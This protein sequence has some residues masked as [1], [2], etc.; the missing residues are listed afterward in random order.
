MGWSVR[1]WISRPGTGPPMGARAARWAAMPAQV[2]AWGTSAE[3]SAVPAHSRTGVRFPRSP[4]G[5]ARTR[6]PPR[7]YR[8][9]LRRAESNQAQPPV[10]RRPLQRASTIRSRQ[11]HWRQFENPFRQ[12][13]RTPNPVFNGAGLV[14][15]FT[16]EP[17]TA[18]G[19]LYANRAHSLASIPL[20]GN[21]PGV[22]GTRWPAVFAAAQRPTHHGGKALG[23]APSPMLLQQPYQ[24]DFALW[25]T[26]IGRFAIEVKGGRHPLDREPDRWR[27][28]TPH[29]T[30]TKASPLDQAT[31][32][33]HDLRRVPTRSATR[34]GR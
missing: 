8:D 18:A 28:H 21:F 13:D 19:S 20:D 10:S 32:A 23:P 4:G 9:R 25:L 2:W 16:H 3:A 24:L 11:S 34:S 33:A 29:G 12:R 27:P 26:G 15:D 1:S 17:A 22:R 31:V 7:R 14:H 5:G 6:Q 30:E